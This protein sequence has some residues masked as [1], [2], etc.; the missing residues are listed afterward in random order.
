MYVGADMISMVK[1]NTKRFCKDTIEN[2]TKDWAGGS[3]QCWACR[4]FGET[5]SVSVIK[6]K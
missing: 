4:G 6:K 2:L 1:N 3:Y 5:A